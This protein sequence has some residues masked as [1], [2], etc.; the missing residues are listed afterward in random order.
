MKKLWT[1]LSVI[2]VANLFAIGGLVAFLKFTGRLDAAR[3]RE[4]RQLF[5]ETAAQRKAK[6]EEAKT[7]A[8]ADAKIAKDD[9][10]IGT[11]PV[12]ASDSLDLKLQQSQIDITRLE[13]LKREVQILQ[14][15][16][17]RQKARLD[18]DRRNLEK[19]KLDFHQARD[20]VA[21]AESDTQFKKALATLEGLKADKAK[22]TLQTLIDQKQ[23]DQVVSYLNA[24]Q[25]RTRTKV[26]DEFV[27]SDPKVAT[28]LLERLRTRGLS[29]AGVGGSQ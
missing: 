11:P 5:S 23:V 1:V 27:K 18:D 19:E 29:V 16:L 13:S 20:V 6:E 17:G 8:E 3:V 22:T 4:V 2:A 15:T 12:A 10:K 24:M 9:A 14:E 7:K 28:D 25:E 26:I 21:K